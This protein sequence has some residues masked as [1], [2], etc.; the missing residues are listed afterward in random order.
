[1]T[2]K[3]FFGWVLMII[4]GLIMLFSGGC[5]LFF[6][7]GNA[8]GGGDFLGLVLLFGG[9]PFLIGWGTYA[10]GRKLTGK[11]TD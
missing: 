4:G 11:K 9:I 6:L 7:F 2:V 3:D 8:G 5:S 10:G 1:M